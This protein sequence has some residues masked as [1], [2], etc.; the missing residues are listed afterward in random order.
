MLTTDVQNKHGI[1]AY[2]SSSIHTAP[3]HLWLHID[4]QY[5]N[6]IIGFAWLGPSEKDRRRA[7]SR[8]QPGDHLHQLKKLWRRMLERPC[9]PSCVGRIHCTCLAEV[10]VQ[11]IF[12][13]H[14]N[15]RDQQHRVQRGHVCHYVAR[16]CSEVVGAL[17]SRNPQTQ[18]G[19]PQVKNESYQTYLSCG[20][21]EEADYYQH[22]KWK[23]ALAVVFILRQ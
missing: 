11:K 4:N 9:V 5:C 16:V 6:R 21:L 19:T 18:L 23:V 3:R 1:H 13:S 2:E 22:T 10:V 14:K 20:A 15:I 7:D 17:C 12:K 8:L